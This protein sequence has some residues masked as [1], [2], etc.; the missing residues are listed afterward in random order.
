MVLSDEPALWSG[1]EFDHYREG[2]AYVVA[3]GASF[4][5]G[6]IAGPVMI[7]HT[8][9]VAPHAKLADLERKRLRIV[10]PITHQFMSFRGG[11]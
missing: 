6:P 5:A 9:G 8:T 11:A 2:V 10:Q 1:A 4:F 7:A 3:P